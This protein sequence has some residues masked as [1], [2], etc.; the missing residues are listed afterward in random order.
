MRTTTAIGA[1]LLLAGIMT[2]CGGGTDSGSGD[3]VTVVA[4][5][6]ILG[7]VVGNVV[8]DEAD[9]IVLMPIG[10]D[11]HDFQA[12]SAQVAEIN[13]ADLVVANGLRLEEGLEDVLA[14]AAGDG[15]RIL[16][17]GPRL[18]PIPFAEDGHD[19]HGE[20]TDHD[21]H[22]D[23]EADH[24]DHDHEAGSA[25]PHV[26]LDPVRMAEAARLIAAELTDVAP[27]GDWASRADAYAEELAIVDQE[28]TSRLASVDSRQLVTSHSALGYFADRYGF[29][30]IGV[31]I[32]GGSTLGDPSSEELSSLVETMEHE[33]V[34]VIFGETT[35]PSALADAVAAELG[36]NVTVVSLYT[37]SL[38]EPGTEASTLVGML[39]TN[40]ERI[41]TAL[42]N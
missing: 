33:G 5:T 4:T 40:A 29:E 41:A 32:P 30:V 21:E 39:R 9:V 26:W 34:S 37:G 25:D 15:V 19:N 2:G 23:E 38:D 18:D 17:V 24:D 28:I 35:Q 7:D 36:E 1:V 22:G 12:S 11:P 42:D 14:A 31:V 8:G 3:A 10:A 27:N 20:E 16:E 13:S 6:T